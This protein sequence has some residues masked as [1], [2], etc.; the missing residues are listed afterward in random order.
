MDARTYI[1]PDL[2]EY[3]NKYRTDEDLVFSEQSMIADAMCGLEIAIDGMCV[4]NRTEELL[5]RAMSVV[6]SYHWILEMI[7]KESKLKKSGA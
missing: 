3:I 7:K 4:D 5:K 2:I 6:S 1:T